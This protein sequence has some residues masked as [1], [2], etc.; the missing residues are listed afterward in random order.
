MKQTLLEDQINSFEFN[1]V[2]ALIWFLLHNIGERNY[3][4]FENGC[5]WLVLEVFE[6]GIFGYKLLSTKDV[7]TPFRLPDHFQCY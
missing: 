1:C 5:F 3:E 7:P 6:I 4:E 2:E